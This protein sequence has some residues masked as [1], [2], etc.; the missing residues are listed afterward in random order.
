MIKKKFLGLV[1]AVL[2]ALVTTSALA[3]PQ[4]AT[5]F[6][7]LKRLEGSWSGKTSDGK[8]V[9][10]SNRVTAGGSA[11]M[12]EIMGHEEMVSM[13]HMDGDRLLMTHYCAAGNQPR[14]VAT[15]SSDGQTITFDFLDATNLLPSQE[16]HMERVV[17][18]LIDA[19]HH[20]EDWQFTDNQGRK[21]HERLVLERQK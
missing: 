14:M 17:F 4:G 20:T 7:K 2:V 15:L 6:E 3:D 11:L 9:Q 1:S 13:F 16:G 10:V 5:A 8:A 21:Q 18:T 12:S 19:D